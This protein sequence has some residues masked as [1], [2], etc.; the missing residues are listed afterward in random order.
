MYPIVFAINLYAH[1]SIK[2]KN[3][4][5]VK[6]FNITKKV[7]HSLITS[8]SKYLL[9]TQCNITYSSINETN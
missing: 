6:I 3:I 7:P 1:K 2:K 4:Q 9:L 8:V 5:R